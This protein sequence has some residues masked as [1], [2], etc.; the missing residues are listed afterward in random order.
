MKGKKSH[1]P[2]RAKHGSP[3]QRAARNR[4]FAI[5]R[6]KNALSLIEELKRVDSLDVTKAE[7]GLRELLQDVRQWNEK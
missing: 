3:G 6:L 1:T 2:F 5:F 4:N 7:E